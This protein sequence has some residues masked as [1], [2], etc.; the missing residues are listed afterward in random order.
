MFYYFRVTLLAL[1]QQLTEYNHDLAFYTK[2]LAI[3]GAIQLA[4]AFF[5][6][7]FLG[8]TMKVTGKAATASERAANDAA[9]TAEHQL[10]AYVSAIPNH[11]Y[12]FSP[13]APV[14]IQ[15][16]FQNL[17]QTPAYRAS[18]IARI[19]LLPDPLPEHFQFPTLT[20]NNLSTHTI[21]P[22]ERFFGRT[23]AER[24]FTE[25]EIDEAIS[26][27]L[28]IY[29]FGVISYMDAFGNSRLTKFC[30]VIPG[31][32]KLRIIATGGVIPDGSL[33]F[34]LTEQH[35]DAT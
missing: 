26:G 19:E 18:S 33:D 5:Q 24:T 3:V 34:I 22:S 7:W 14:T 8:R 1:D 21:Q 10:R 29:I 31:G 20:P 13:T 32:D 16:T 12:N 9:T 2:I 23:T 17:G 27:H 11:I 35:N 28:R 30:R 4:S 25:S 15:Y 6:T